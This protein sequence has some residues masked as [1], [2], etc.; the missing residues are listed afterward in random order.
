MARACDWER[1]WGRG[2][3]R[4]LC[5]RRNLHED[6]YK[7]ARVKGYLKITRTCGRYL[8]VLRQDLNAIIKRN[9]L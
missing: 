8:Y 3:G 1:G 7:A 4:G 6:F 2:D 5:L 9:I